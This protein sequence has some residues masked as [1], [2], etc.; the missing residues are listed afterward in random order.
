[1]SAASALNGEE[2]TV[3]VKREGNLK[4]FNITPVLCDDGGYKL[5]LILKDG[6]SGVGTLTFY[7]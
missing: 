7:D 6:I 2:T 3:T 5:G 1:M 4:Q